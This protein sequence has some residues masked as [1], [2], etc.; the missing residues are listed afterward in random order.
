MHFNRC[1]SQERLSVN[2]WTAKKNMKDLRDDCS[3]SNYRNR[4]RDPFPSAVKNNINQLLPV[5]FHLIS[6]LIG[7]L[8]VEPGSE[9]STNQMADP[10]MLRSLRV[11]TERGGGG[12]ERG[13][14]GEVMYG[15][16]HSMLRLL[17]SKAQE[18]KDCWQPSIPCHVGIHWKAQAEYS[19]VTEMS[20][21]LPGFQWFFRFFA[22][23]YIG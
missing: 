10:F 2:I 15:L 4:S 19:Q 11:A 9:I 22:S 5:A 16:T 13:G 6:E 17:S 23:F 7:Y 18:R 8:P 20:T 3:C 21:H 12:G 1:H 14:T